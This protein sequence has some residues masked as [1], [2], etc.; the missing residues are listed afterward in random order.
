MSENYLHKNLGGKE[1][2][3]DLLKV[4]VWSGAYGTWVYVICA[5]YHFN[6]SRL[7]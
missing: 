6:D 5:T 2:G 1:G 7:Y 3:G 4:G